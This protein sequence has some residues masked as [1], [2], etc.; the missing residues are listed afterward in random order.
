VSSFPPAKRNR[1]RLTREPETSQLPTSNAQRRVRRRSTTSRRPDCCPLT[2][3]RK[4]GFRQGRV[5][6]LQPASHT[7]ADADD[8]SARA[9]WSPGAQNSFGGRSAAPTTTAS[10]AT[11]AGGLRR[12]ARHGGDGVR[13]QHDHII[14]GDALLQLV[15][16]FG[17]ML[18]AASARM[19]PAAVGYVG[20]GG[21]QPP[22]LAVVE[23]SGVSGPPRPALFSR[24]R[25]RTRPRSQ[26]AREL[27][28]G[29]PDA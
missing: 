12:F 8:R 2:S 5:R 25:S 14:A 9:V 22:V 7:P 29:T 1:H 11:C 23:R 15:S 24:G 26:E 21:V 10:A 3:R 13:R 16:N 27:A 20:C 18:T 6:S 4:P 17:E 28:S 19:D